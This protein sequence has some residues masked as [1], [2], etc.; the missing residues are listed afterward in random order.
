MVVIDY[1]PFLSIFSASHPHSTTLLACV[2]QRGP[3]GHYDKVIN[4]IL[5]SGNENA[6]AMCKLN[7]LKE[8]FKFAFSIFYISIN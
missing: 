2:S 7:I 4:F 6:V 8:Y 3:E 5:H 1:V